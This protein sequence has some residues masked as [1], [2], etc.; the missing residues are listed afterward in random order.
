MREAT[1]Y[2]KKNGSVQ[3]LLCPHHCVLNEGETGDCRTRININGKLMTI[4]YG[5]PCA[6]HV[7]PIEKKPLYHF[8]PGQ[9][10]FSL[11]T[12]GCN[13]ACLNCQNADISQQSPENIFSYDLPPQAVVEKATENNTQI[14]AYTYTDPVAFYEYTYDTAKLAKQAGLKNVMISAGYINRSLCAS[15]PAIWMRLILT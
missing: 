14:I 10:A 4:A 15:W 8:L 5:N 13:L 11:A 6:L 12:A 7:D 3:C 1:F 2:I 9:K